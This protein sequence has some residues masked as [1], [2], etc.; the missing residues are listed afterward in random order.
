MCGVEISEKIVRDLIEKGVT[1]EKVTGFVSKRTGK[2]F[3]AWLE[4]DPDE[5]RVVFRFG[6]RPM[7]REEKEAVDERAACGRQ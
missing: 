6:N 2:T 3:A 4:V 1:E 7:P 5:K